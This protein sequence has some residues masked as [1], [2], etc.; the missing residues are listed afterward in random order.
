M[1][2]TFPFVIQR[3]FNSGIVVDTNLLVLYVIG[4]YDLNLIQRHHKTKTYTKEDFLTLYDLLRNFKSILT[5]P[6]ILTETSN[7]TETGDQNF[8]DSFFSKFG[9]TLN[10]FAE[11][12]SSSGEL[13]NEKAFKKFGL[14]D[15]S[16]SKLALDGH[17]ILTDDLRLSSYLSGQGFPVINFNHIRTYYL[18]K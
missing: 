1:T 11:K 18:M 6:N 7:L 10:G 14:A 5:T 17:L 9:E 4:L 3:Y 13:S 15:S 8:K 2:E 12:Y 16:I